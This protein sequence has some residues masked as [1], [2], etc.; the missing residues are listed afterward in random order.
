MATPVVTPASPVVTPAPGPSCTDTRKFKFALTASE[1]DRAAVKVHDIGLR[2]HR[3]A[4]DEACFE[5]MVGGGL[6]RTPFIAKTIR[7]FL[8]KRDLLSYIEAIV[9]VYN[10]FGRRDNIYKA[11]F[12]ILVHELGAEAFAKEVEAEIS[13]PMQRLSRSLRTRMAF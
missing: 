9:R 10:Q 11:R 5:V 1:H 12:K 4:E 2:L 6:G 3:N 13:E 8:P 7:P